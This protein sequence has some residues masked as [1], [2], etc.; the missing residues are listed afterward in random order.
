MSVA[1]SFLYILGSKRRTVMFDFSQLSLAIM[2]TMVTQRMLSDLVQTE[3]PF[4]EA[5]LN[6]FL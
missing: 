1:F 3:H 5:F 2:V 6:H 4:Y